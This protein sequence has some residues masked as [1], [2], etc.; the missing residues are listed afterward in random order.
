MKRYFVWMLVIFNSL[1]GFTRLIG[2]VTGLMGGSFSFTET[3]SFVIVIVA[4]SVLGAIIILRAEGNRVGWLMVLLGFVLADPFATYLHFNGVALQTQPSFLFYFAFWTQGWFYFVIIYAIF[5]I[6]LHFP[7][8]HPP[9]PR[10]NLINLISIMTL[11]Q[12][13]LVYTFQPKFGDSTFLVDNPIAVLSV[14]AEETLSG[15][16]FGLGLMLLALSSLISIFVRFKRAGSVERSQI[17]WLLFSGIVSFVSIGYRLE[18]YEPGVSDWTGYLLT[19]ALLSVALSISIAI[20]RYRLYD[21]DIII[22][23]TLQYALVTGLLAL[24]YFGSVV[25]LQSL[26]ENLT[27]EQSPLVIVLSTLAIAALF[28]PLRT[29]VQDFIDRRF[30]RKK[31][32][33]QNALAHFATAARDE[34]DLDQLT[35]ALLSV[36]EETVQPEQVFLWLQLPSDQ[37]KNG[38]N[39][40]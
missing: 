20:L 22:R 34:V 5:L 26:V 24:V 25:I 28:N 3:V 15:L 31:Y 37:N 13:I 9:S 36:V 30:Y 7:D 10:W 4:Y 19:I 32:D 2:S 17:K 12:F 33:A 18:T 39:H 11:G 6:I 27:G 40:V 38:G 16:I 35:A 14:S 8:G 21:I 1:I 29:R 23:R